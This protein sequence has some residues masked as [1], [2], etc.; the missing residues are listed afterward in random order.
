MFLISYFVFVTL[1]VTSLHIDPIDEKHFN[2]PKRYTGIFHALS[3]LI[4][5]FY[6]YS[7]SDVHYF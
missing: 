4:F 5:P 7:M 1:T 3:R 2:Q 6:N